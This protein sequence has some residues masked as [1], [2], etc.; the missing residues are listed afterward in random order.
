[1][2]DMSELGFGRVEQS[3]KANRADKSNKGAR[4]HG[5]KC[6]QLAQESENLREDQ[7]DC[8]AVVGLV[9]SCQ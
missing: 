2:P 7:G 6:P 8:G 9:T 1:M 4:H 3:A 5:V